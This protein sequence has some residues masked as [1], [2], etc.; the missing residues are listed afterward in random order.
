MTIRIQIDGDF[1]DEEL[2]SLH[3]WLLDEPDIR[4]NSQVALE[5]KEPSEGEMGTTLDVISL[6]TTSTLQLPT[7]IDTINGWWRTRRR[8]PTVVIE[9]NGVTVTITG[10][11]P[12][13]VVRAL[14]A[15]EGER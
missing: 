7:V 10:A 8:E 6:L 14:M 13:A 11:D 2:S 15:A 3:R 5:S 12:A 9:R 4:Q 1:A